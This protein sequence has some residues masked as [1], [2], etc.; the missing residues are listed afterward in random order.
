MNLL[1]SNLLCYLVSRF[2]WFFCSLLFQGWRFLPLPNT[3]PHQLRSQCPFKQ[4]TVRQQDLQEA[5]SKRRKRR[6]GGS[7]SSFSPTRWHPDP[8][9]C[10]ED[11]SP[12]RFDA[13]QSQHIAYPSVA[14]PVI[15]V[16]NSC[17]YLIMSTN[18]QD[19]L[20]RTEIITKGR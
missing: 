6:E 17:V 1:T 4:L 2:F 18:K 16:T 5:N 3:S 15:F 10:Q 7:S 14:D 8:R 12:F 11:A 9:S 20:S 13:E 19:I